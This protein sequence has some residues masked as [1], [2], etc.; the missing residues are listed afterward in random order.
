MARQFHENKSLQSTQFSCQQ[1]LVPIQFITGK[2]SGRWYSGMPLVDTSSR[3]WLGLCFKPLSKKKKHTICAICHSILL[4]GAILLLNVCDFPPY[5][6]IWHLT[7]IRHTYNASWN[8]GVY[9]L[10][11][12]SSSPCFTPRP[13]CPSVFLD[14]FNEYIIPQEPQLIF[15]V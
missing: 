10:P 5:T 11:P 15:P 3:H 1:E 14:T 7:I 13:C 12:L 2:A 8:E 4:F 9:D 6:L